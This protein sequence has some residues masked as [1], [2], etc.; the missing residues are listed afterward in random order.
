MKSINKEPNNTFHGSAVLPRFPHL[1]EVPR[2]RIPRAKHVPPGRA[3]H[4]VDLENLM[5][6]PHAGLVVMRGA[7]AHYQDAA[8]VTDGDHIVVGVNPVLLPITKAVWP[9][10]RIEPG[11]GPDGADL[12]LLRWVEDDRF[13]GARYD[14][15]VVGSGDGIFQGMVKKFRSHGLPVGVVSR[16]RSLSN[17]LGCAATYVS[18]LPDLAFPEV[19]A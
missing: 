18:L 10:P 11:W 15:I 16:K 5:G 12:A 4:L 8:S 2:R 6:G 19:A 13:I 7:I 14:R 3:L 9:S 1:Y 17:A